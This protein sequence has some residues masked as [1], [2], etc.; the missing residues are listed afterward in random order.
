M[1]P[2]KIFFQLAIAA[3]LA[4]CAGDPQ[5]SPEELG[6][7][8]LRRAEQTGLL[9]PFKPQ[10]RELTRPSLIAWNQEEKT[11]AIPSW[12][13]LSLKQHELLSLLAEKNSE[14]LLFDR[15]FRWFLVP[16]E[17]SHA[18]EKTAGKPFPK[19]R[20][21]TLANDIATAFYMEMGEEK[22][23]SELESLLQKA[24]SRLPAPSTEKDYFDTN[25]DEIRKNLPLFAAYQVR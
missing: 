15:M 13:N 20:S 22:K 4:A 21:E 17:L 1:R 24:S 10:I 3:T 2:L 12:E 16:H 5:A 8:F 18:L 7:L 23:L 25:Y 6:K 9:L 11:L 14:R 19:M